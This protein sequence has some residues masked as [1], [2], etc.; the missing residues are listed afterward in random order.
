M[1]DT[2]LLNIYVMY[3]MYNVKVEN[4]KINY[5]KKLFYTDIPL[6]STKSWLRP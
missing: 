6:L 5:R 4:K 1:T 3:Y 2:V